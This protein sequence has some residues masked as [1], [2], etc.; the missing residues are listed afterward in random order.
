MNNKILIAIG[1]FAVVAFAMNAKPALGPGTN[2]NTG[3]GSGGSGSGGSGSNPGGG[4]SGS[5]PGGSGSGSSL[6]TTVLLQLN[7]P[8]RNEVA[9]LQRV[10]NYIRSKLPLYMVSI[11]HPLVQDGSFGPNTAAAVQIIFLKPSV[12]LQEAYAKAGS[13][14][15]GSW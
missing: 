4:G 1:V 5:N 13:G 8:Y 10:I 7:S 3:G 6:N 11:A 2:T 14:A 9:E 15:S 12:T